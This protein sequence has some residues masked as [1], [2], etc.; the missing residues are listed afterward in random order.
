MSTT[1][2]LKRIAAL[3]AGGT[4]KVDEP[5]FWDDSG[6]VPWVSIG[7]MSDGQ[8]VKATSRQVSAAGIAAKRLPVGRPGTLLFAMYASVGAVGELS[9]D[10][11]WNQAL[12]GIEPRQ[13]LADRR[14]IRFWLEHLRPSLA[15]LSRSNTQDNL[16][17]EQVGNFPFPTI[18]L[19]KQRAI[20]DYLDTETA[21]ID[22]LITKKR[23]LIE[24]LDERLEAV[25]CLA[26]LTNKAHPFP[27]RWASSIGSGDGLPPNE[28][29]ADLEGAT[30]VVGGNG[31]MGYT[32]RVSRMTT[33]CI[34]V[35]R[36]GALCGNVHLVDPP[37]WITDNALWVRDIRGFER[38][39]LAYS[40]V[41]TRLNSLAE[42]TAQPLITG[43]ML[44]QVTLPMPSLG[45][46]KRIVDALRTA[47]SRTDGL[48][49]AIR[50]QLDL[51][52]EKRQALITEAVTGELEIP[53]SA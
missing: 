44:K 3:T 46:Q 23:R 36:V 48:T 22:A 53:V 39:F 8:P 20:A 50:R 51:L 10:A 16:N 24:L 19:A 41:A 49:A 38:D 7:D 47:N 32:A 13:G 2:K 29:G 37:A 14:F 45:E 12:L 35:G 31:V 9:V 26:T 42:K 6:G 18:S 34:A 4:P 11:T 40:L 1:T 30:P 21:R 5:S 15:A 52:A 43:E 28:V 17:A 33:P 27:L 25:Q